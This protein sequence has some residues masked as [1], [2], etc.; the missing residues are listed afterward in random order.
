MTD[1]SELMVHTDLPWSFMSSDT[2]RKCG[3]N[4]FSS[5]CPI[6]DFTIVTNTPS[7]DFHATAE[8]DANFICH[9]VN[10][11]AEMLEAL[12]AVLAEWREGYGLKCIEQVRAAIAK[13]TGAQS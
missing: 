7:Y 2:W 3:D 5:I 4:R 6:G 11:H 9:T 10:C 12:R 8:D 13:A 1:I